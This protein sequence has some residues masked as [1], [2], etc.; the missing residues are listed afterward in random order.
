M[1]IP[2][3][4]GR[5]LILPVLTAG[6]GLA[7]APAPPASP[8]AAPRTTPTA[9]DPGPAAQAPPE[10]S[11]VPDLP[12]DDNPDPDQCGIPQPLGDGVRGEVSGR[13]RG[14]LLFG[15]VHLYDSHLRAEVAG[16]VPDGSEVQV[17]MF[18]NNP[19][20]NYWFVRWE[21]PEGAVEGWLPEPFL[22][23]D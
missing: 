11:D 17:L 3:R 4:L 19:V 13:W 16:T 10:T 8:A 15:D 2:I 23:R 9:A 20:L 1:R 21:G 14:E 18:Q 7:A 12:F 22:L 6:L 5:L